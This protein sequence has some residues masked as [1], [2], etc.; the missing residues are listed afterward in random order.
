M[1]VKKS[2]NCSQEGDSVADPKTSS[3]SHGLFSDLNEELWNNEC[4]EDGEVKVSLRDDE[5]LSKHSEVD[6]KSLIKVNG[7]NG[8]KDGEESEYSSLKNEVD[9]GNLHHKLKVNNESFHGSVNTLEQRKTE[10]SSSILAN[11][12]L[13]ASSND[14][15]QESTVDARTFKSSNISNTNTSSMSSTCTDFG[16]H[17]KE[18]KVSNMESGIIREIKPLSEKLTDVPRTNPS[19]RRSIERA[20]EEFYAEINLKVVSGVKGG[21]QDVREGERSTLSGIDLNEETAHS[22]EVEQE[23]VAYSCV[24]NVRKPIPVFA[25]REV[26]ESTPDVWFKG[27][28]N[29]GW[30]G[31]ASTTSAFRP[32]CHLMGSDRLGQKQVK[33]IDLNVE[34]AGIESEKQSSKRNDVPDGASSMRDKFS[35]DLNVASEHDENCQSSRTVRDFDLNDDP[36]PLD[37]HV[38]EGS[39]PSFRTQAIDGHEISIIRNAGVSESRYMGPMLLPHVTSMPFVHRVPEQ[40]ENATRAFPFHSSACTAPQN[41]VFSF[42]NSPNVPLYPVHLNGIPAFHGGHNL[43]KVPSGPAPYNGVKVG[44]PCYLYNGIGSTGNA[45]PGG[46]GMQVLS[47]PMHPMVTEHLN[48]FQHGGLFSLTPMKR[49]EPE[50]SWNSHLAKSSD[51]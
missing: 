10:S 45:S 39:E 51:F 50:G 2:L 13:P 4:R 35:I 28:G 30:K 18:I 47:T 29:G 26:L 36:S 12:V 5:P 31:S 27:L 19:K 23:I 38:Q 21:N 43:V 20:K 24:K 22:I 34:A 42:T 3:N 33:G 17:P 48:N 41:P 44:P 25:R 9:S 16:Y 37:S 14:S 49:M 15:Y 8:S 40:A 6:E 46:T 1:N 32:T 7:M 11:F